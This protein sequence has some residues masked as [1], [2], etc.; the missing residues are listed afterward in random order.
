MFETVSFFYYN[1]NNNPQYVRNCRLLL[2]QQV[3]QTSPGTFPQTPPKGSL[4]ARG[5]FGAIP[6]TENLSLGPVL[7][8]LNFFSFV[9]EVV[10]DEVFR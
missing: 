9:T 7:E 2:Q 5:H 4:V 3:S 10:L 1:D 8:R 6:I